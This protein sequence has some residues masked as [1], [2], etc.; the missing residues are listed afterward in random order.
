[1]RIFQMF[2]GRLRLLLE[3]RDEVARALSTVTM[4]C[5]DRNLIAMLLRRKY[6]LRDLYHLALVFDFEWY[7]A[8]YP[9]VARAGVNPLA[10]YLGCGA[11]EGRD[12]NPLFDT[13]WYLAQ[14]PGV[15][16]AHI[17]P[18]VHYLNQGAAE[19]RDPNPLFDTDW[20][21]AQKPD[22]AQAHINPLVHYLNQGAAEGRDPNPLF[23]TDWYLAQNPDVAQAHINPLVHYLSRGAAEGRDPNPLFDTDWYLAQNPHVAR[24][25][26]NPLIHFITIGK[27]EGRKALPDSAVRKNAAKDVAIKAFD[28]LSAIDPEFAATISPTIIGDLPTVLGYSPVPRHQAWRELFHSLHQ[29]YE[30]MIFVPSLGLDGADIVAINALRAAHEKYG[31]N[32]TLLVVT[33]Q[34]EVQARDRLPK[35][36]HIR[37]LSELSPQLT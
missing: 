31:I 1:M 16:Q 28:K 13:D 30:R 26:I 34:F 27:K 12:P 2:I 14:N 15:A 36:S 9:D 5:L 22:V 10:D 35:G 24:A 17:N 19:G 29:I 32:N 33:D 4:C 7:L 21:L 18:L 20:Y 25:H 23:D 8:K 11:S 3:H 6:R 37:V